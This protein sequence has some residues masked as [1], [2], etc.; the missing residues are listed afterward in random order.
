MACTLFG[1]LPGTTSPTLTV[2]YS[3]TQDSF[4]I[5]VYIC[6]CALIT[7]PSLLYIYPWDLL[8]VTRNAAESA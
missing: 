8:L 7:P 3:S 2:V 6:H 5:A 4:M 1:M